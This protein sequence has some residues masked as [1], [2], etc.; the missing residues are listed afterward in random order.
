MESMDCLWTPWTLKD[1]YQL[2]KRIHGVHGPS[3]DSMDYRR[4][5]QTLATVSIRIRGVDG[6]QD[7]GSGSGDSG[8]GCNASRDSDGGVA[9]TIIWDRAVKGGMSG[10]AVRYGDASSGEGD[11]TVPYGTAA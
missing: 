11:A 10:V 4:I 3:M 8:G 2:L 1:L 9:I 5:V 6:T 7:T